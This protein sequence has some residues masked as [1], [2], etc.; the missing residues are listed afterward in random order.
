MSTL[1]PERT[2]ARQ[3]EDF[4]RFRRWLFSLSQED[5]V[6]SMGITFKTCA[7]TNEIHEF[8]LLK[9]IVNLQPPLQTPVHPRA[10]GYRPR[11]Q[12][13]PTLDYEH[14]RKKS[15]WTKP[16]LFQL[17]ER[18]SN[19]PGARKEQ[20]QR[21]FDVIARNKVAPWGEVYSVGTTRSQLEEDRRILENTFFDMSNASSPRAL[22]RDVRSARSII[23]M[24]QVVSRG[25][26]LGPQ[27]QSS[28]PFCT[29]WLK[30]TERWFSLSF[31]VASRYQVSLWESFQQTAMKTSDPIKYERHI[32]KAALTEAVKMGIREAMEIDRE[33]LDWLRDSH[34]WS[35]FAVW[36]G[37][38][39]SGTDWEKLY[40]SWIQVPLLQGEHPSS[41]LRS[42]VARSL[43]Q[44][45]A[46]ELE[47][48]ILND[49]DPFEAPTQRARKKRQ[50][51]AKK[52]RGRE[53]IRPSIQV[54]VRGG[55]H[56][57]DEIETKELSSQPSFEFPAND[58][59]PRSRNGN[60]IF[61]LSILEGVVENAFERVGLQVT[62]VPEETYDDTRGGKNTKRTRPYFGSR[63]TDGLQK[64]VGLEKSEEDLNNPDHLSAERKEILRL[65]T[66]TNLGLA[67]SQMSIS[68]GSAP[69]MEYN[70]LPEPVTTHS[71]FS[72]NALPPDFYRPGPMEVLSFGRSGEE[73]ALDEWLLANRY[74]IRERS[75][76]TDFFQ[77]QEERID[78]DENL[79]A[80][81][82]AASISSST[83]K[84]STVA[85]D[86]EEMDKG[87]PDESAFA[88]EMITIT[89]D[90]KSLPRQNIKATTD[91]KRHETDSRG[92]SERSNPPVPTTEIV[93]DKNMETEI[94][95]LATENVA[96]DD[97]QT[98]SPLATDCR[99][100]SPE[101]PKT[102]PP[103]LS[104][105]LL[106]LAD[107]RDLRH[108]SL[109]PERRPPRGDKNGATR[110]FSDAP[111]PGSLPNSPVISQ[112][113]GLTQS[114]SREDLRTSAFRDDQRLKLKK[115]RQHRSH[116]AS[117]LQQT[118]KSVAVKSLAKPIASSKSGS[119]D[120]RTHFLEASN[121]RDQQTESCTRSETAAEGRREDHQWHDS[122]KH[123][124]EEVDSKSVIK[125][126]TTTIT[127]ALS[128]RESEDIASI[129][130]GKFHRLEWQLFLSFPS[131]D[132][133]RTQYVP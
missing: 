57:E 10:M 105:I 129:R 65:E 49:P 38:S 44:S 16:R 28:I 76:L 47:K 34:T 73:N 74:Q 121:K 59:S 103:T 9:E 4:A 67:R 88:S 98:S 50:K 72:Q 14:G 55:K 111:T 94:E 56:L 29:C 118:Y 21:R 91:E 112:K 51:K 78:D 7:G 93:F 132:F 8:D 124:L 64:S 96:F 60:V 18:L 54:T 23:R 39:Y 63:T 43:Q 131:N 52:R 77:S 33:G 12:V 6:K 107:L 79:M 101:A 120:F 123:L 27:T 87:A 85:A 30:P 62:K 40:M 71:S 48:S 75:I 130:D 95:E 68:M 125:D 84:D 32:L 41:K 58:T 113:D 117:E 82:T 119:V 122:R 42:L 15:R 128:Q 70:P 5:L 80:A 35:L 22:F 100:P 86:A 127:S 66:E 102:P 46:S 19:K 53:R 99:S 1:A 81:S 24:L 115:F 45:L 116:R 110:T 97:M 61:A 133:L 69:P 11:S 37:I 109:T 2:T 25:H 13:G 92:S 114:W 31:Y 90:E 36:S 3:K 89:E 106:S 104:P 26:F 126:E 17:S 20:R 83:Y 108:S